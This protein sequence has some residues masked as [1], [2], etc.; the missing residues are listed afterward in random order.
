MT[1]NRTTADLG[2]EQ[3]KLE[4]RSRLRRFFDGLFAPWAHELEQG[5]DLW[6]QDTRRAFLGQTPLRARVLVYGIGVTLLVLLIWSAFASIDEVTRGEGKV[7]PSRKVQV[8]QSQDGGV[9]TEILV[10]EGDIVKKG[11]LLVQLDQ[12]RSRS[13]LRQ[14]LS[15]YRALAIKEARLRAMVEGTDFKPDETIAAE[16]PRIVAEETALFASAMAEL[17]TE[18]RIAEQRQLQAREELAENRARNAQLAKSHALTREELS[19]TKPMVASGAVSQVEILRLEKEVNRLAGELAQTVS[20]GHR[21][22]S[23]IGQAEQEARNIE[24]DWAN[25]VR[26]ELAATIARMNGLREEGTGLSDRVRQTDLRS[27]VNGAVKQLHF[28]TIGGVVLPGREIIEIVPTDDTLLLEVR[29]KPRDIAF[30]IPGQQAR[31]KFTAYDFIVYGRLDGVVEHIGADTV[32]DEQGEPFYQ[33]RVRTTESSLGE[34][35][36]IIPGMT[37]GVDILTGKKSILA[38]LMKPVLR[39]KQNAMT[40]R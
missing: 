12:T 15:E 23:A 39:A 10:R 7:I 11:Q 36:P 27:P 26:E 16:V 18:K 22:E 6:E 17:E 29:I 28:N 24:L 3:Q 32:M 30:L 25:G 19:L 38:Y 21:L 35:M 8:I 13:N 4:D 33:V 9:L 2:G 34:D 31:V 1:E 5:G 40:E 37:V 14:N 20:K